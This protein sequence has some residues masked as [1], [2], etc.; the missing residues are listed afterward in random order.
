MDKDTHLNPQDTR[1][2]EAFPS[3]SKPK[4]VGSFS[5]DKDRKYIAD[6][7]NCKHLRKDNLKNPVR[8][9]LNDGYE[10]AVHKPESCDEKLD[11]I[12]QWITANVLDKNLNEMPKK[13]EPNIR[14]RSLDVDFVCFRGLLRMIMCTPYENRE[15]WI[16]LATKFRGT[17]YLCALET[18]SKKLDRLNATED[19]KKILA[20]GYK[21]E[22]FMLTGSVN[23]SHFYSSL[24]T[25]DWNCRLLRRSSRTAEH[26]RT[27]DR[28]GRVLLHVWN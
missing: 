11:H 5:V 23:T 9:D 17:I 12:L 6:A 3:F 7:R 14:A 21:F 26:R 24:L 20:F 27:S 10:R 2:P 28:I 25:I 8:F 19:T 22:Q 16:I 4:I 18:E 1:E 15:P 13:G